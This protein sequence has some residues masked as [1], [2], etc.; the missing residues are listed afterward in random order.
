M[1][2]KGGQRKTIRTIKQSRVRR[3]LS[4]GDHLKTVLEEDLSYVVPSKQIFG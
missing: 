3:N 1:Q 2:L 4:I